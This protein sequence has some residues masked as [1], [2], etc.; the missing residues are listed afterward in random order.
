MGGEGKGTNVIFQYT[1]KPCQNLKKCLGNKKQDEFEGTDFL[2]NNFF[3][4][5]YKF[6]R[7]FSWVQTPQAIKKTHEKFLF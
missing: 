7:N 4:L 5:L 6:L 3:A 2:E 1:V